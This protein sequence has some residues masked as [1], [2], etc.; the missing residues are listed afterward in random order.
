MKSEGQITDSMFYIMTAL[1]RPRHGY[2]IMS[3]IEETTQGRIAIGPASMYTIIKK[4][5]KQEWIYLQDGS[6][7]RRKV[8]ELTKQGKVVLKDE[9]NVRKLMVQLAEEGLGGMDN[10]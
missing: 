9:M 1:T 2:A 6:D 3:L 10:E 4:L 5:L 7:S 8:Y